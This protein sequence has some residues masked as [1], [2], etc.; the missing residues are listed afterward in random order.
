MSQCL[1]SSYVIP[2]WLQY[3]KVRALCGP[4]LCVAEDSSWWFCLFV[5]GHC[6]AAKWLKDCLSDDWDTKHQKW[7]KLLYSTV[8]KEHLHPPSYTCCITKSQ[9]Q[10]GLK[11]CALLVFLVKKS[12]LACRWVLSPPVFIIPVASLITAAFYKWQM[13][14]CFHVCVLFRFIFGYVYHLCFWQGCQCVAY[15]GEEITS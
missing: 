13:S 9:L 11:T 12:V 2:D 15:A 1:L 3:V 7:L 6:D 8:C 10:I 14:A 5:W 4:H